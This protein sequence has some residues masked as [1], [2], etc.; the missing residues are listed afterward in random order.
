MASDVR[1]NSYAINNEYGQFME[2]E[3]LT[4]CP[5]DLDLID[6]DY[7][8][9]VTIKALNSYHKKVYE[10]LLP[11]LSDE[12]AAFLREATRSI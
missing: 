6:K 9:D 12:E 1:M 2:F 11:Y 7:L 10:T 3:T 4:M 5:F 8:D